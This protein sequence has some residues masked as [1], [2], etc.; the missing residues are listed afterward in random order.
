MRWQ[1]SAVYT[2]CR[3][4]GA[5]FHTLLSTALSSWSIPSLPLVSIFTNMRAEK[6]RKFVFSICRPSYN[7]LLRPA[8]FCKMLPLVQ[9]SL[10]ANKI[11]HCFPLWIFSLTSVFS[12]FSILN[13]W[14]SVSRACL[15]AFNCCG[16][17]QRQLLPRC[18][19]L[20]CL[21]PI[22]HY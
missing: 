16:I 6:R 18:L 21:L 11:T 5:M 12:F 13:I 3:R 20:S 8:T 22:L 1:A 10:P 17:W 4:H 14:S 7:D 15:L 19:L 2:V 9:S